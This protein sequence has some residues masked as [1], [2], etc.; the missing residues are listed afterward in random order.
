M[1]ASV[2]LVEARPLDR[3][4]IHIGPSTSRATTDVQAE[5][6]SRLDKLARESQADM[7]KVRLVAFLLHMHVQSCARCGPEGS[8]GDAGLGAFGGAETPWLRGHQQRR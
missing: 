7:K 4:V 1:L 8:G 2:D 3:G 6:G 5:I